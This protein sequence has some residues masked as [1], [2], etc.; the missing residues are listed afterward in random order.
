MALELVSPESPKIT[1]NARDKIED[2]SP[3]TRFYKM[4][5]LLLITLLTAAHMAATSPVPVNSDGL[6]IHILESGC[7]PL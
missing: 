5:R 3:L 4:A 7:M 1:K 6:F 2:T